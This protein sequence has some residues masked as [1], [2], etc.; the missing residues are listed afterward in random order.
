LAG[1][2]IGKVPHELADEEL[3]DVPVK[4]LMVLLEELHLEVLRELER[5]REEKTSVRRADC[6]ILR[7]ELRVICTMKA[8][9]WCRPGTVSAPYSLTMIGFWYLAQKP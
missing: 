9:S 8:G 3:A 5:T 6:S 4:H 1:P 2:E 7:L